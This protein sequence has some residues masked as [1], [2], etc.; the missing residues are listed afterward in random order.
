MFCAALVRLIGACQDERMP[1]PNVTFSPDGATA[2]ITCS[3]TEAVALAVCIEENLAIEESLPVLTA[4]VGSPPWAREA[5]EG[6][7]G[8][9][10]RSEVVEFRLSHGMPATPP[11]PGP[12][13]PG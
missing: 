12:P 13:P 5:G 11:P 2:T 9:V 1:I 8:P 4:I 7:A 3:R 10:S 6:V